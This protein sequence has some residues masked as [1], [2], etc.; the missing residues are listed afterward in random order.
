MQGS[1]CQETVL[2]GL[3]QNKQ[4]RSH[5]EEALGEVAL[6]CSTS[7]CVAGLSQKILEVGIAP[8]QA[9][10]LLQHQRLP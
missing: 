3:M 6:Q 9:A 4:L 5:L 2:T 1:R 10:V 8:G 7:D